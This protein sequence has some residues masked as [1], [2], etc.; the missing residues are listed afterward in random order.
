MTTP[1]G[2]LRYADLRAPPSSIRPTPRPGT[3]TG[4]LTKPA[5]LK[6]AMFHK[7]SA[8]HDASDRVIYNP[9]NG[10]LYYDP[11]GIGAAHA[12][13]IATLPKTLKGISYHDFFVV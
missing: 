11:D 6:A 2:A 8:A 4:S 5:H 10:A 12:V 1:G 7:G 13:K 3:R 9:K